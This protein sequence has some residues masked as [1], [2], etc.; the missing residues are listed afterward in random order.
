MKAPW[1]IKPV[2]VTIRQ[3]DPKIDDPYIYSTWTRYAYSHP[4]EPILIPKQEW[5][6][7]KIQEIKGILSKETVHIA[8][9]KDEPY[10]VVGYI[11]VHGKDVQWLCI[12][13]DYQ[14]Q[15]IDKLLMDS[16][17]EKLDGKTEPND[18]QQNAGQ[19][20]SL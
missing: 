14:N 13:K 3:Y 16:M 18:P 10:M 5:H 2:I 11:V 12:K 9:I 7:A 8:C 4:K 19:R 6:A 17:K 15:G 20:D 1:W